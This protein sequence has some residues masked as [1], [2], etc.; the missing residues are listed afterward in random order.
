[1]KLIKP[2]EIYVRDDPDNSVSYRDLDQ[3]PGNWI[4]HGK[5]E[6][7]YPVNNRPGCPYDENRKINRIDPI[8][9]ICDRFVMDQ[10]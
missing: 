1:M 2:S 10:R 6:G 9:F 7:Q 5:L 4:S 8:V 3:F